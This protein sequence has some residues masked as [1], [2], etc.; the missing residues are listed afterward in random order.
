METSAKLFL[1]REIEKNTK[2]LQRAFF[3][4]I[5]DLRASDLDNVNALKDILQDDELAA[6]FQLVQE[7]KYK[8]IRKVILDSTGD[9]QRQILIELE[10]YDVTFKPNIEIKG[11]VKGNI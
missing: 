9:T 1:T 8:L 10:N 5:D 4:L 11:I 2:S 3:A 7:N 6:R